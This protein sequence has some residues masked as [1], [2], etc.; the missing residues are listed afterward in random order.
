MGEIFWNIVWGLLAFGLLAFGLMLGLACLT[1]A[2]EKD[3]VRVIAR[4]KG[5]QR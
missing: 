5:E 2:Y 4:V 3:V 1:K